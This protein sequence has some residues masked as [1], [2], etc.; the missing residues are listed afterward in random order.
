MLSEQQVCG[1]P[2]EGGHV[3][4]WYT[5]QLPQGTSMPAASRAEASA[6]RD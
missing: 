2:D 6:G 1:L 3:G 5:L 4:Q